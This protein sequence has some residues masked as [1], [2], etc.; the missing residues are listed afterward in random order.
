LNIELPIMPPSPIKVL[1]VEDSPVA[2]EILLRIFKASP[3]IEVVGTAHN[4]KEALDLIPKVEPQVICTDL[5][6]AGMDGLE[7]TKQVMAKYPRPILVISNSVQT[8]DPQNVFKL[9]QAGA[10]DIL[11]K[12]MTGMPTDYDRIKE[13]LITR[14]KVLAGVKVF[15]RPLPKAATVEAIAPSAT[16]KLAKQK[17]N[18]S[19]PV[20]VMVIGSSTG[21]PQALQKVL[22]PLPSNFPVPILCTQHIS[23]GFLQGLVD[24][25]ASESRLKVKIAQ[26]GESP[27]PGTVY[28]APDKHHLEL[29]SLGKFIF[30][31]SEKVDGHCPSVTVMFKSVAKFYHKRTLGI[32]L[33][34]MGKDGAAGLG[35]IAQAG[36]VTIAQDEKSCIVF[37]M[38]KEAIALGAVQHILP[39]QDIAPILLEQIFQFT[40]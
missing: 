39:I 33:T 3:A 25:L 10:V 32:L 30:Q 22:S 29:N 28:F 20:E 8:D 6:M 23:E 16:T 5:H 17:F 27:V 13:H 15:T 34:G 11:P 9:L 35:A 24:W 36:G 40:K 26:A 14:I 4:G 31:S 37:G 21:G 18:L 7:L 1:L 2:V 12:P 38:P 19:V